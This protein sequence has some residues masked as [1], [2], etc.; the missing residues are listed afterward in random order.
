VSWARQQPSRIAALRTT[1][2]SCAV[3]ATR[4]KLGAD[5]LD[6]PGPVAALLRR[7][8]RDRATMTTAGSGRGYRTSWKAPWTMAS[9]PA[10]AEEGSAAAGSLS[11]ATTAK[12][13]PLLLVAR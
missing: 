10:S 4:V 8:L 1:D 13:W 2:T 7:H 11:I 9:N 3:G 12:V 5:W 6:V